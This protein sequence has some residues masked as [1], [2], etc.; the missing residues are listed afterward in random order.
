MVPHSF[1]LF[2]SGLNVNAHGMGYRL[3][4]YMHVLSNISTF[5]FF[6]EFVITEIC[7]SLAFTVLSEKHLELSSHSVTM[8]ALHWN[9]EIA[10]YSIV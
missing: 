10:H 7:L 5:E 4:L 8:D 1:N 6:F 3:L 2:F 9:M